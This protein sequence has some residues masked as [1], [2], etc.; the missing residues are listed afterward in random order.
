MQRMDMITIAKSNKQ[1]LAEDMFVGLG[2]DD[3]KF[4]ILSR[5]LTKDEALDWARKVNQ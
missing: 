5:I 3:Y 4:L 2:A 1:P